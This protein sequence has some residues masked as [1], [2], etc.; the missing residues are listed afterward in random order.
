MKVAHIVHFSVSVVA[1]HFLALTPPLLA[2]Q[3]SGRKGHIRGTLGYSKVYLDEPGDVMVAGSVLLALTS[4]WGIEPEVLWITGDRFEEKGFAVNCVYDFRRQS[5]KLRPYLIGGFGYV[6]ELDKAINYRRG[7]MMWN[8]G[9]G[10]R[11]HFTRGLF[12]SPEARF[13][14]Q[15]VPRLTV[16]LGYEF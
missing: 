8:G 6:Q 5:Q 7:E 14:F 15:A 2:G 12:V 3:N 16:S 9:V 13:G 10:V 1:V 4:H 11:A